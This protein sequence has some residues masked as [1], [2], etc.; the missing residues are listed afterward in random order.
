MASGTSNMKR[1]IL[2]CG[3][4]AANIVFDDAPDLQS[5]ADAVVMRAFWNQGQVCTAS[6][7]LLIQ[8]GIREELLP[9]V[10]DRVAALTPGDPLKPETKFAALVSRDHAGKVLSYVN[11]GLK[12]GATMIHR[13]ASQ[14]P[15]E[16]GFYVPPVIFDR[17]LGHHRIAQEEIFGPVLSVMSFRDEE[18]AVEIANGLERQSQFALMCQQLAFTQIAMSQFCRN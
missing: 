12:E 14:V 11:S 3:G 8:E 17:V 18:E 10:A 6:S 2:E 7:R 1:L 15:F 16:G 5:V 4:K 13:G 9:L